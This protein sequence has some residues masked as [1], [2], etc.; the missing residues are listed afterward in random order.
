MR[1]LIRNKHN[2]IVKLNKIGEYAGAWPT[3]NLNNNN[4]HKTTTALFR[5]VPGKYICLILRQW[6]IP[7][8]KWDSLNFGI[9][10][11]PNQFRQGKKFIR[12]ESRKK[13]NSSEYSPDDSMC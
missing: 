3:P 12:R 13:K 5:A 9:G 6:T 11:A 8:R 1:D 2:N 10:A 4:N 7:V